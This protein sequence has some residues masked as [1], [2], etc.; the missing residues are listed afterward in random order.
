MEIINIGTFNIK[1]NTKNRK[2]YK[3]HSRIIKELILAEQLDLLGTQELTYNY[4]NELENLMN[5]YKLFGN[6]RYILKGKESIISKLPY[7]ETNSI[8]TNRIVLEN[9]T[10]R[11]SWV[12]THIK[13]FLQTIKNYSLIPRIATINISKSRG[14]N[15]ICMINTHLD[16]G[17][18]QIQKQQLNDL[19][20]L[21]RSY[22]DYPTIITG[23][24]NMEPTNV[25]FSRFISELNNMNINRIEI[26]EKTWGNKTLDHIF[27]SD[28]IDVLD[29]NII[30]NKQ[31]ENI[32]D[33]KLLT[34]KIKIK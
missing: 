20:Q 3:S 14:N 19:K 29:Y 8:L 16:Y 10:I 27:V 4:V 25:I 33:H 12:P 28:T 23:D 17:L 26:N 34:A 15:P 5:G 31:V 9:S 7:N 32:S 11:L 30:S 18:P 2:D 6:F 21:I 24:F 1:N 13:E 22:S